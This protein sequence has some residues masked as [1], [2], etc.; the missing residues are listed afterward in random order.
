MLID[1][2][3]MVNYIRLLLVKSQGHLNRLKK[4]W[5]DNK[6]TLSEKQFAELATLCRE[7]DHYIEGLRTTLKQLKEAQNE[8]R[9]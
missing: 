8:R 3:M 1:E 2:T 4:F 5:L 9:K 7:E 6:P